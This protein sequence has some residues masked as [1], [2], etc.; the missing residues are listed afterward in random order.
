MS[1]PQPPHDRFPY[2]A[3][4][5]TDTYARGLRKMLTPSP[6]TSEFVGMVSY[7]PTCFYELI[8]NEVE[9]DDFSNGDAAPSHRPSWECAMVDALG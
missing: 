6:L 2:D 7:A 8:G 9:S 5:P 3:A 1:V 4:S